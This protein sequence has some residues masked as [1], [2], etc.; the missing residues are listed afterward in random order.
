MNDANDRELRERFARLR[1]EER[2]RAPSFD[3]T[4][5]AA[6]SRRTPRRTPRPTWALAGIAVAAAGI[7]VALLLRSGEQPR[8]STPLTR[9]ARVAAGAH[10]AGTRAVAWSSP[11]DFLLKTPGSDLLRTVPTFETTI[12]RSRN[13]S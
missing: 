12:L 3:A 4:L 5:A 8:Y 9:P 10:S 2:A 6:L 1:E 7:V 13:R 11:T